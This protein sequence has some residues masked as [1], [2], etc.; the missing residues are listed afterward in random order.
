MMTS[1]NS[2]LRR[3]PPSANRNNF[4]VQQ[5][6]VPP[7]NNNCKVL[8]CNI[9]IYR[10]KLLIGFEIEIHFTTLVLVYQLKNVGSYN[11]LASKFRC[12]ISTQLQHSYII[13]G[14]LSDLERVNCSNPGGRCSKHD[15]FYIYLGRD[16][17]KKFILVSLCIHVS[18]TFR[19]STT[20]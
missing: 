18:L 15:Y 13:P 10:F 16:Y 4:G 8:Q 1:P 14:T 9:Q 12:V 17:V 19:I 6:V 5:N 11:R 20:K 2:Y 7:L 3:H